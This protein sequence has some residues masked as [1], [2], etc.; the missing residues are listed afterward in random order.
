L[1]AETIIKV[2]ARATAFYFLPTPSSLGESL[3]NDDLN[4]VEQVDV[5]GK[6]L[7]LR[8]DINSSVVEG[9]VIVSSRLREHAQS[10]QELAKRGAKVVVLSHQGREGEEDFIP[11]QRHANLVR[12]LIQREVSFASWDE[13][14][15]AIIR[16]L[17]DGDILVLDN[18]R[19]QKDE[20]VEKTPLEHS[21]DKFVQ[22]LA[23]V[24]DFFVEDALSICHRSHATVTGFC[25][26][27]PC[28]AGPALKKELDA[29]QRLTDI[30]DKKL[31]ILGGAKPADSIKLLKR[32]LE[33]GKAGEACVGGLFGELFL[34]AQGI[35]FGAKD[36]FF[37]EKGFTALL[38][39]VKEVLEKFSDRLILPVDLA[40]E[41]DGKRL[42]VRVS[43]LPTEYMTYD[44]GRDTTELF[45]AR[46]RQ[47]N[48]VVFNGPLGMYENLEFTIG[49]KKVLETLAFTKKC[50]SILGGGDTERALQVLGLLHEDF[51]HVSLAG[52]A[53]L[54]FLSGNHLPGLEALKQ[55][56][57]RKKPAGS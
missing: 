32:M 23:L 2:V 56:N 52:K 34:K 31:C 38:P 43:D 27:L 57:H 30:N 10:I 19:F 50:F 18:T 47:A 21:R 42:E 14:Y 25:P 12:K 7:L 36:R 53:L 51:S 35:S 6:T 28:F 49:T 17:K 55:F 33:G 37:E 4:Y 41:K 40:A 54:Q 3:A 11:L 48:L 8:V 26:L 29:L 9:R 13:D 1:N 5:R 44:I 45:K 15:K 24:S 16:K 20:S 22:E 39:Q 46:I